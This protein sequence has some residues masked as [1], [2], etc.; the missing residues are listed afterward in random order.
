MEEVLS[1]TFKCVI[2][3]AGYWILSGFLYVALYLE[4]DK[5]AKGCLDCY[6]RF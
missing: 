6:F 4:I 2:A 3:F 5:N 1:T